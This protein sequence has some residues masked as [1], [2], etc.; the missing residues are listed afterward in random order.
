MAAGFLQVIEVMWQPMA[1]EGRYGRISN[2]LT[3]PSNR[4]QG[5]GRAT[6]LE[7]ILKAQELDLA[8]LDWMP[9]LKFNRY[10]RAWVL[11]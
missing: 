8:Y 2:I 4:R 1:P 5:L 11:P 7:L 10:T 6:T 9:A 3:L